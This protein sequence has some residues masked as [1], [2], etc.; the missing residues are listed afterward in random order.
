MKRDKFFDAKKEWF[1]LEQ[2]LDSNRKAQRALGYVD[3]EKPRFAGYKKTLVLRADIANR[4]DSDVFQEIID[5]FQNVVHSRKKDF[6]FYEWKTRKKYVKSATIGNISV[7]EYEKLSPQVKK[8][9]FVDTSIRNMIRG[10]Y[11]YFCTIPSFY[12]EQKISKNYITKV[13]V[14]DSELIKEESEIK[15]MMEL[16][17]LFK[18]LDKKD[19]YSCHNWTAPQWYRRHHNRKEK[20]ASKRALHKFL[21]DGEEYEVSSNFKN[22]SWY[23]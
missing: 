4:D 8:H 7:D 5:R 23:W 10:R 13:K 2:R 16:N 11:S 9:F 22:A 20:F 15:W 18:N 1:A 3:L 12:F 21:R 17:P 14:I 6:V 19:R